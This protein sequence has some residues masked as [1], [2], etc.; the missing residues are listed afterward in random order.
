MRFSLSD[1][2]VGFMKVLRNRNS[3]PSKPD[4]AARSVLLLA[5]FVV[6]IAVLHWDVHIQAPATLL[7]GIAI[8][9]GG[10]LTAFTHIST[11]RLRLTERQVKQ[12]DSEMDDRDLID[13]IATLLLVA[14]FV[15]M[16]TAATLVVAMNWVE[17]DFL[18]QWA[19]AAV[20]GLGTEV[21]ALFLLTIPRLYNAY[22]QINKVRPA[23]NGA[24]RSK[25]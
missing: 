14:A 4:H 23:L 11:L 16:V 15:S 24:N 20:A 13:E 5:P 1:L 12:E 21:F 25:R 19:A 18:Y 7:T 9:A 2:V 8:L 17:E 10:F 22:L 3:L 6:G